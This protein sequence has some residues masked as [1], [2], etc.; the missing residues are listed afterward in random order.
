MIMAATVNLLCLKQQYTVIIHFM[1]IKMQSYALN[2]NKNIHL[3][4]SI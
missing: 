2:V 4:R 1:F 3:V